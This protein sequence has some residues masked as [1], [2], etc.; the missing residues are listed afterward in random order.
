MQCLE[1]DLGEWELILCRDEKKSTRH[2]CIV[3]LLDEEYS[4]VHAH[5]LEL[6]YWEI[7]TKG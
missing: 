6:N 4:D 2:S 5:Y 7:L 1:L 3:Q